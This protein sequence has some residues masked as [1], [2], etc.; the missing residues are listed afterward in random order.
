VNQSEFKQLVAE[1]ETVW[2][3]VPKW[4]ADTL[5]FLF[6]RLEKFDISDAAA[7]VKSW[8]DAGHHWPPTPAE[9]VSATREQAQIRQRSTPAL[10][11]SSGE[12][13]SMAEWLRRQ[14]YSSFTELLEAKES[15]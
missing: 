15:E 4:E 7:A 14:G 1:I 3:L 13:V 10:P 12:F 6:G 9:L 2:P 5:R 11:E 8:F